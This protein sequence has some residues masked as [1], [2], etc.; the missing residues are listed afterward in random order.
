M[1]DYL[2]IVLHCVFRHLFTSANIDR[3]C[4]DLACDIAVESAIEDLHL[5]SAA[6]N[7]AYAQEETLKELRSQV[8]LLTAEKLYRYFLD[9]QLSDD[10]MARLRDPFLADD[11]RAWYLPVKSGQGAGGRQP[12]QRPDTGDRHPRQAEVRPGRPGSRARTPKSGTERRDRDLEQ[13][14]REISERLQVDLE[15]ISRRHGTD[16][17][18]LVQELKAVNRETYDYADFLRRYM[19]LGEV[20]QVNQD[21]FDYIYYTY[22]LS[23]YGNMPLVEP[24]EYK[25][26]RRIKE[27]V[28]AIDT[29]GSVSGD[30][31]QRFVTKTYNILRQQEN[32]FTKINLHIIQCDAE[33]QEDRKITSQK[34]F[35][36][37][38]DTM[39]AVKAARGRI[40]FIPRDYMPKLALFEDFIAL[41][42][43]H[44]QHKYADRLPLDANSM[45]V[46]DDEKQ[47]SKMAL[48]FYRTIQKDLAE[49]EKR[50]THLIQSG[51]QSPAIMDRMVLSIR[52]LERK[53]IYYESILKQELHEVDEQYT[54]LRYLSDELQIRARSIQ[55]QKRLAA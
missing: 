3:R 55:A 17:G 9:R 31:V 50:A 2:H 21:E 52:E 35:D 30:L 14:W 16:A 32:F 12:V 23:L 54:S 29:S 46:V 15:T 25:E 26:V 20:T 37:Y 47:R 1:R 11:H 39:Q 45:F 36:N 8:R 4:W 13:T 41:L 53:K 33:V 38:L 19:S 24:L 43:Q 48:A 34:D 51:N 7:R 18:N 27:F 10:Q 28:I 42:E 22:G 49:Y 44:N 40:Y 5:E 6:C